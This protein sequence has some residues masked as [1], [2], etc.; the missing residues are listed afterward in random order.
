MSEGQERPTVESSRPRPKLD[1]HRAG[2]AQHSE[3]PRRPDIVVR[4]RVNLLE[5]PSRERRSA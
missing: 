3:T 2:E 4:E 5:P 1:A